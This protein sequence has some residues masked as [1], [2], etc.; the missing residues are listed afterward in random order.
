MEDVRRGN[1]PDA[2]YRPTKVL[3]REAQKEQSERRRCNDGNRAQSDT[4]ADSDGRGATWGTQEA[5]Q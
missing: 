5:P 1:Y 2:T 3:V 4:T